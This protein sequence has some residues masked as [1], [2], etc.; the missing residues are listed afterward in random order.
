MKVI[1]AFFYYIIAEATWQVLDGSK[2]QRLTVGERGCVPINHE[3]AGW[4]ILLA[5]YQLVQN[6][7]KQQSIYCY[8]IK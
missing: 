4:C 6:V 2:K 8:C 7:G 1:T 3:R 5:V